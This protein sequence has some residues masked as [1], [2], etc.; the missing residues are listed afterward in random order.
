MRTLLA[1]LLAAL[2]AT[3]VVAQGPA[4]HWPMDEGQGDATVDEIAG[5]QL[6]LEGTEWTQTKT[7]PALRFDADQAR[8]SCDLADP[9][10]PTGALT[11]SLWARR[12]KPGA[13]QQLVDA[14]SG[15]GDNNQGYRLL[16][17]GEGL[18]F[19]LEAGGE[20]VN[21]GGGAIINGQ[22]H[23]IAVTFDGARVVLYQD[24]ELVRDAER[25]GAI[26]YEGLTKF[27]VGCGGNG[28]LPGDIDDLAIHARALAPDEVAALYQQGQ[29]RVLTTAELMADIVASQQ[30]AALA[31]VP[32]APWTRDRHTCLLASF[33]D[34]AS[35]D[36]D[37]ARRDRRAAGGV[38][39]ADV[40]GRFAGGVRIADGT[41]PLIYAG[42]SNCDMNQGTFEFWVRGTWNDDKP[43]VMACVYCEDQIGY[44]GRPG[45]NLILRKLAEPNAIELAVD[46]E[47]RYWYTHLWPDRSAEA[48]GA[49]LIVPCEDLSP[50]DWHHLLVSWDSADGGRAWLTVDG[51][52]VTAPFDP[53]LEDGLVIP[54]KKVYLGGGYFADLHPELDALVDDFRITDRCVAEDRLTSSN[55]SP[56]AA[57]V[58][59]TRLLQAEDLARAWLDQAIALQIGG[60]W[61]A[62]LDWPIL[63]STESPGTYS[64]LSEDEY[65]VRWTMPAMLRGWETLGDERYLRSALQAGEMLVAVQDEAGAWVQGYIVQPDGYKPVSAGHGAIQEGTQADPIRFL[66][67]LYRV[68]GD[69]RFIEAAKKGGDFVILAQN[70]DGSWPLG[71]DSITQEPGSGYSSYSTLND[72]TTL[73]G[74]RTMLLMYQMTGEQ[75]FMDALLRA[76]DFL[77]NAQLPAPTFSWCEQYSPDG[78]PAWA[79]DWEPAHPTITAVNYARDALAMMYDLTGHDRYLEPLR[80]CLGFWETAPEDHNGYRCYHIETGEPID[81]HN[82]KVY[83]LGHAEFGKARYNRGTNPARSLRGTLDVRANGP[84][85]PLRTGWVPRAELG[86]EDP[87]DPHGLR[88]PAAAL[89]HIQ[90]R[91][92]SA[93]TALDAWHRGE[94]DGPGGIIASHPRWGVGFNLGAGSRSALDVFDYIQAARAAL[95]DTPVEGMSIW[96]DREFSYVDPQRDWYATPL[97]EQTGVGLI[98]RPDRR[99][100]RLAGEPET[101]SL[102]LRNV[103]AQA[104]TVTTTV[105]DLPGDVTAAVEGS[106]VSID[107]HADGRV[108]ITFSPGDAV[109]AGTASVT[110][111]S[112]AGKTTLAVPVIAAPAGRS[113]GAEAED[114]TALTGGFTT[115][116]DNGASA[117]A[118]AGTLRPADFT[119]APIEAGATDNGAAVFEFALAQAGT[120]RLSA[121]VWWIDRGGNSMWARMDGGDDLMIGNDENLLTWEWVTGPAWELAAGR[122]TLRIADR[123]MGGR[124]DRVFLA[125]AAD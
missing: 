8:A 48:A 117:S 119:P 41:P 44:P 24:G 62:A 32:D 80:K 104:L 99:G 57:G 108:A 28:G 54:C 17:Y 114:A 109:A 7:G 95:G 50:G 96:A 39:A 100:V 45:F 10:K 25:A 59:E 85:V 2:I 47:R 64:V 19:M 63:T 46:S 22:W 91:A 12:T 37:Y 53:P 18:R 110:L 42:A 68:T 97:Q 6:K 14:G 43:A 67:Y 83:P 75:R 21:V 74:M 4:A 49:R 29:G 35:N 102:R 38:C 52:G 66:A 36:A 69:E 11:V 13:Y 125:P 120:Y 93:V 30:T 33:D 89:Q 123:E 1:T 26:S 61:Q 94:V 78:E 72:G 81:A 111:S 40:P 9:L 51:A 77:I 103:T 58:D 106:P 71:F 76:G 87:A 107:P 112:P 27:Y 101:V 55:A 56:A 118:C 20:A 65:T 121:R 5:L 113:F 23:H 82:F 15:W 122:H 16:M 84:L 3:A 115:V 116:A 34:P 31:T 73:W 124:L 92:L 60:A 86:L 70:A 79:R 105:A 90:S 98:I 88:D